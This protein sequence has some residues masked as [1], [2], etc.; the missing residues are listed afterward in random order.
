MEYLFSMIIFSC[1]RGCILA[2]FSGVLYGS[3]FVPVFYIKVHAKTNSSM[4]TGSSENGMYEWDDKVVSVLIVCNLYIEKHFIGYSNFFFCP[5]QNLT[6][7]LPI[8]V[9]FSL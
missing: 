9:E 5:L 4:F 8:T 2:V 1:Y 3:S 7:A 6:T